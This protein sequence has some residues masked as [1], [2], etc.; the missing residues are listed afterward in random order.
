MSDTSPLYKKSLVVVFAYAPAGLGHLRVTDALYH[1]LPQGVDALLLSSLGKSVSFFHRLTSIHPLGRIIGEW[2]Q[3]GLPETIITSIYTNNLK[4]NSDLLYKQMVTI[5]EQRITVPD[6]VL[7]IATHFGLAH[8]LSRIK[9]KLQKEK[10]VQLILVVQV[11]DDSP[12]K[13]WYVEGAD[14]ICVP[15]EHTKKKLEDYARVA[16]LSPV[17]LV[18]LPYPISPNLTKN[19]TTNELS[20]RVSQLEV[21]KETDIKVL[22]PISGAA[23]G[24]DYLQEIISDLHIKNKRFKFGVVSKTSP[25]TERFITNLVGKPYVNLM[26]STHDRQTVDNYEQLLEKEIF[27]LEITKPSEQTFKALL[28]PKQRGGVILLFAP[29]VGRQEQD[30]INYLLRLN[31]IPTVKE[32]K[33]LFEKALNNTEVDSELLVKARSWRGVIIPPDAKSAAEFISW[34][35]NKKILQAMSNYRRNVEH[36]NSNGVEMFWKK[37]GTLV[38]DRG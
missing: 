13:F 23:V 26:V 11:T 22:I 25:Y 36:Q 31:L 37:V 33:M 32:Q 8:Q 18:V 7:V 21:D 15:S 34:C 1:G 6:T 29:H 9:E 5:L 17:N 16:N 10:E 2:M 27:S 12:Q 20:S 19:L 24:I 4:G 14:L 28:S 3:K 38:K 30:N 35:L